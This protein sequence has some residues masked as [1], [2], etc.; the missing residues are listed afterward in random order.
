MPSVVRLRRYVNVRRR[1]TAGM[2]RFRIFVR[3]RFRCLYCGAKKA[4]HDLTLDHITPRAPRRL[5]D[6]ET[7]TLFWL[8]RVRAFLEDGRNEARTLVSLA[9]D[10]AASADK[11]LPLAYHARAP[12]L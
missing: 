7:L 3:D 12:L 9:N 8:R 11:N 10:L 1:Q 6:H 4:A 2:R 5:R